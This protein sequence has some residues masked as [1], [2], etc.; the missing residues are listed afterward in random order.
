MT[1]Q[2]IEIVRRHLAAWGSEEPDAALA[3][4][5]E[6]VEYDASARPGGKIWHGHDGV[7]EAMRAMSFTEDRSEASA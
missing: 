1:L 4:M 7:R 3:Y 2:D 5:R 6:D